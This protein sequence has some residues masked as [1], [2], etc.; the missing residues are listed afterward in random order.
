LDPLGMVVKP[1]TAEVAVLA[2][3]FPESYPRDP[4]DGLIAATGKSE[5]LAL[6]TQNEKIR[7]SQLLATI[8]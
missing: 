6:V 5:G 4:A 8:C 1:V 7:N 2:T 3:S